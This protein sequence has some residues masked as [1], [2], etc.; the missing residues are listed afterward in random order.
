MAKFRK[1]PVEIEAVQYFDSMRYEDALPE[2]VVICYWEKHPATGE[3][4]DYPTIHTLEGDHIVV[5]GDWVITGVKGECYPIKED[6]F[7]ATY[8]AV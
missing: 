4:G 3:A 8:D 1:K 2:G 7:A 6:I 5:D